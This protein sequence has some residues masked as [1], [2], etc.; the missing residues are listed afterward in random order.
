[1]KLK[2]IVA[3]AFISG[4]L[5]S[6]NEPIDVYE[7]GRVIDEDYRQPKLEEQRHSGLLESHKNMGVGPSQLIFT[8]KADN[9]KTY[10]MDVY[11]TMD[12]SKETVDKLIDVGDRVKFKTGRKQDKDSE[13][14]FPNFARNGTGEVR[15]DEIYKL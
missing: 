15:A 9:G 2:K 10:I 8:V 14:W 7:T 3:A 13:Y 1:M 5:A 11:D 4:A 6:C 12:S